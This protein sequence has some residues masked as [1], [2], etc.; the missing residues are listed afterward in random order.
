VLHDAIAPAREGR[1]IASGRP[2]PRGTDML[3]LTSASVSPVELHPHSPRVGPPSP[4]ARPGASPPR[5][6]ERLAAVHHIGST[7]VPGIRAKPVVDL[8]AEVHARRPW[9]RPRTWCAASAT[10]GG[11]SA[12]SPGGASARWRTRSPGAGWCTS[13]ATRPAPRR[14]RAPG[15]RDY[16]RARPERAREY[17]AEKLR[18]RGLWP[19]DRRAYTAAKSAWIEAVTREALASRRSGREG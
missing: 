8:L 18:C 7:A 5:W 16:L 9:T 11:A 2:T 17:E 19:D 13:T 12:A 10:T 6:A 14:S 3:D 1:E 4:R 15:F